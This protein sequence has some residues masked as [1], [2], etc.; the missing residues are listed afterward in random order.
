MPIACP[1]FT[2][3]VRPRFPRVSREAIV[4][5]LSLGA[6]ALF[7]GGVLI[8]PARMTHCGSK[9]DVARATIKKYAFE[10]YP[11]W[12]AHHERPCPA[13]L[14]EL[15]EY[16]NNRHTKDPWGHDYEIACGVPLPDSAKGIAIYSRGPDGVAWTADDVR[17]WE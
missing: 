6:T 12:T 11:Q 1:P 15:G 17:S 4:W 8:S 10:A 5:V 16:M 13:R 2:I 14:L 3:R 9:R 7:V